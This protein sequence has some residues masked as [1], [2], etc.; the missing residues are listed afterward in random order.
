MN[1][2]TSTRDLLAALAPFL[3]GTVLVT[4]LAGMLLLKFV[5]GGGAV[6][7]GASVVSFDVL[8]FTNS[9]RAIA[10]AFIKPGSDLSGAELLLQLPKRTRVAIE[11]VA[12][13]GTLVVVKQAVVQGQTRDITDDV[14]KKLGLPTDVPTQDAAAYALDV[15]PTVLGSMSG[16][17]SQDTK[18]RESPST[19]PQVLP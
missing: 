16:L 4:L 7:S 19:A 17:R 3:A 8:K 11:E 10:S 12:G 18:P 9:Q 13:S 6:L 2:E 15:A 14:L 5:G 1:E